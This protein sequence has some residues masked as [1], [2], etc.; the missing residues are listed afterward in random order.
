MS[1]VDSPGYVPRLSPWDIDLHAFSAPAVVY[2]AALPENGAMAAFA[3]LGLLGRAGMV[4]EVF[5]QGRFELRT[6]PTA[7]ENAASASR[8][9]G[10]DLTDFSFDRLSAIF[11]A[12]DGLHEDEPLLLGRGFFQSTAEHARTKHGGGLRQPANAGIG[13]ARYVAHR[14]RQAFNGLRAE[15][16]RLGDGVVAHPVPFV[17]PSTSDDE[18]PDDL[19]G[20]LSAVALAA[21]LDAR[22]S[23]QVTRLFHA[24]Q[25]VCDQDGEHMEMQTAAGICTRIGSQ[26]FAAH[27]LL[28]EILLRSREE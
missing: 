12:R 16:S 10:I 13:R 17:V 11:A 18:M 5:S 24:I 4:K 26:F 14:A 28:W 20:F 3:G 1:A 27:L 19:L 21:R 2:D 25:T 23:D 15:V 9:A 8:V 6:T 22:G 7:F